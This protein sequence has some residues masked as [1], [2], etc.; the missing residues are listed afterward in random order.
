MASVNVRLAP[1]SAYRVQ[2]ISDSPAKH[3]QPIVK[4][5][6]S[7][8]GNDPN[9]G[10]NMVDTDRTPAHGNGV[11][12]WCAGFAGRRAFYG[13]MYSSPS[14]LIQIT[15]EDTWTIYETDDQ[16][17]KANAQIGLQV[18]SPQL[19]ERGDA[20]ESTQHDRPPSLLA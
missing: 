11:P 6:W 5:C 7:W 4:C 18:S 16:N 15:L 12:Y 8:P 9:K 1:R 19:V 3:D 13:V 2:S 20:R 17:Q 14:N 10:D